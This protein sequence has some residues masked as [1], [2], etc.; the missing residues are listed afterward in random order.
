M[1]LCEPTLST[2]AVSSTHQAAKGT[3]LSRLSNPVR[4]LLDTDC[5]VVSPQELAHASPICYSRFE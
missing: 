2:L 3:A 1:T 4:M 5:G